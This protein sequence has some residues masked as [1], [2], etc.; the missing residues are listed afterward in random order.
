MAVGAQAL[1]DDLRRAEWLETEMGSHQA[2]VTWWT[3]GWSAYSAGWLGVGAVRLA[4]ADS[5]PQRTDRIVTMTSSTVG[6][7]YLTLVN[8]HPMLYEAIDS[9]GTNPAAQRR[10]RA[11][12]LLRDV[13]A[14]E[15]GI[16]SVENH[17]LNLAFALATGAVVWLLG[18][19]WESGTITAGSN[20]ASSLLT[21][22]TLPEFAEE[23]RARYALE[24]D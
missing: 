4:Y 8:P 24:F 16:H 7:A 23:I 13:L 5:W 18:T 2:A 21:I 17:A 19:G 6:L 22:L 20:W 15:H 9:S 3:L 11:E 10:R 12:Q 1:E 14:F